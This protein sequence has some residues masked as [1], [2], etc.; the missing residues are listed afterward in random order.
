MKSLRHLFQSATKQPTHRKLM[1]IVGD[2]RPLEIEVAF[3]RF[4]IYPHLRAFN[5]S[6]EELFHT[7]ARRLICIDRILLQYYLSFCGFTHFL[8]NE[9]RGNNMK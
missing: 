7:T 3:G 8:V 4:S 2:I 5:V 6:P 9:C 1:A